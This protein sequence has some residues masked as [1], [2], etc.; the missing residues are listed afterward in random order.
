MKKI[1]ENKIVK[2][3]G[4]RKAMTFGT[5]IA[6]FIVAA[7]FILVYSAPKPIMVQNDEGSWHIL[8]QGNL[9]S[10]VEFSGFTTGNTSWLA[11]L[12]LDY[13]EDPTVCLLSNA[14]AGNYDTWTNVSGY[15]NAD[16]ADPMDLPSEDPGY[17]VVRGVFNRTHCY[18]ST[19]FMDNRCSIRLTVSGDET[20]S[21]VEG[22]RIVSYNETDGD[23]LYINYYWDDESDGYRIKDD[24][25]LVWNITISAQF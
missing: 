7:M 10:A 3:A 18:D 11:T 5:T 15:Q 17:F 8:W 23:Y 13:A 2:K 16:N 19:K 4:D 14:T 1:R 9:A 24:G 20:I 25:S 6:V 12:V 22:T 21:D